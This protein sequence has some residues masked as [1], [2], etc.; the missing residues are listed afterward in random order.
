MLRNAYSPF[1]L[2]SVRYYCFGVCMP[3]AKSGM[4]EHAHFQGRTR[5]NVVVFPLIDVF[6]FLV[7]PFSGQGHASR[8]CFQMRFGHAGH[9]SAGALP[10]HWRQRVRPRKF[11]AVLPGDVATCRQVCISHSNSF[12]NMH[13]YGVHT[14]TSADVVGSNKLTCVACKIFLWHSPQWPQNRAQ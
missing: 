12:C 9:V 8:M 13:A 7:L 10:L 1:K 4:P 2:M 3:L 11:G 5:K 14:F 6:D